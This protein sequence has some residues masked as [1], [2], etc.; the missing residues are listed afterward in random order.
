MSFC[1]LLLLYFIYLKFAVIWRVG[2]LWSL[3]YGVDTIENMGR[4]MFNNYGF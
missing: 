4:C 3:M 2:R 1:S